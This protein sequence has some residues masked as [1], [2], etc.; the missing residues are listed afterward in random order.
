MASSLQTVSPHEGQHRAQPVQQ[1]EVPVSAEKMYYSDASRTIA[2]TAKDLSAL[3]YDLPAQGRLA[4][5]KPVRVTEQ[6]ALSSAELSRQ[7]YLEGNLR[8]IV[9]GDPAKYV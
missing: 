8:G 9:L 4:Q 5:L 2:C 6:Q 1:P 3:G 7:S